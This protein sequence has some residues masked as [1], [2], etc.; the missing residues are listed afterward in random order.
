MLV[1]AG[2]AGG[3]V[4]VAG[5]K[6]NKETVPRLREPQAVRVPAQQRVVALATDQAVE[7]L[8]LTP[9][10]G[11]TVALEVAGVFPHTQEELLGYLRAQVEAKVARSGARVIMQDPVLVLPGATTSTTAA[12]GATGGALA[13]SE[14][15]DFKLLVNVSW[16]G[17]DIR[18]KETTDEPLLTKQIGLAAT[19]LVSGVLLDMT[20]DS[21]FRTTFATLGAV[22]AIAGAGVWA[23]IKSPFP[24]VYTLIGRVRIVA[25]GIPTK[26]GTAFSTEGSA[27]SRIVDDQRSFEGYKVEG[28]TSGFRVEK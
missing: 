26:D 23:Y 13:L 28:T 11:K 24:H 7:A 22:G 25:Q 19:G 5:C 20:S 1:L 8:D 10:K 17:I 2:V 15:P 9:L 6:Y 27:E 14:P 18:D 16:G 12:G 21:T 3:C 4:G